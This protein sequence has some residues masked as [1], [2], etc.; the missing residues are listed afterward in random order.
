MN[1]PSFPTLRDIVLRDAQLHAA[2]MARA[3]EAGVG[4]ELDVDRAIRTLRAYTRRPA[5]AA[6]VEAEPLGRMANAPLV[7]LRVDR[8]PAVHPVLRDAGHQVANS[9]EFAFDPLL[10]DNVSPGASPSPFPDGVPATLSNGQPPLSSQAGAPLAATRGA[11][12]SAAAVAGPAPSN[13]EAPWRPRF[14]PQSPASEPAAPPD[15]GGST[16]SASLTTRPRV[17]VSIIDIDSIVQ[18]ALA[19]SAPALNGAARDQAIRH[20]NQSAVKAQTQLRALGVC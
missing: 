3:A 20:H 11:D 8:P 16:R 9:P 2:D 14:I 19:N 12:S 17:R 18:S 10:S 4:A 6:G 1:R 7:P 15:D 13:N 5:N